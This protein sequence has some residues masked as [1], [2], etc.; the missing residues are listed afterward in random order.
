MMIKLSVLKNIYYNGKSAERDLKLN[1]PVQIRYQVQK[2]KVDIN[3]LLNK[4]KIEEKNQIKNK[5]FFLSIAALP[6]SL[7]GILLIFI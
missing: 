3:E 1:T 6:I 5:L 7:I 2:Q 4:V